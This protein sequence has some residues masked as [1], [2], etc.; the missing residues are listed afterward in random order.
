ML[1]HQPVGHVQ[2]LSTWFLFTAARKANT[3]ARGKG[4]DKQMSANQTPAGEVL[5]G[6]VLSPSWFLYIFL[7]RTVYELRGE[8]KS[9]I[10]N[11]RYLWCYRS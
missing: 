9:I 4:C 3:L 1:L 11:C 7:M 2:A 6:G 8:R 10:L 5:T